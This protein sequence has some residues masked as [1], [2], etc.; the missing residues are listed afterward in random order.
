MS[1]ISRVCTPFYLRKSSNCFV[2]NW[3]YRSLCS[4]NAGNNVSKTFLS[5]KCKLVYVNNSVCLLKLLKEKLIWSCL[6]FVI[7]LVVCPVIRTSLLTM[8]VSHLLGTGFYYVCTLSHDFTSFMFLKVQWKRLEVVGKS[9]SHLRSTCY[10]PRN[11]FWF[12][13]KDTERKCL[14]EF[15][16]YV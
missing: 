13:V 3:N 2:N 8:K 11:I 6:Y 14:I 10:L 15:K 4:I 12:I 16:I 9:L 7:R 1:R 5:P